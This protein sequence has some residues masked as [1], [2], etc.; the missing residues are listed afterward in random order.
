M[1]TG[2]VRYQ[3]IDADS[4]S[5]TTGVRTGSYSSDAVS[6]LAGVVFKPVRN[7]SLY[8]NYAEGLSQG[9]VVPQTQ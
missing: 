4:F 7:V 9:A 8:A 3:K 6:P 5:N 2:G 1:I